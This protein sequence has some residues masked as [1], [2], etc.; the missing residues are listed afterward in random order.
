M[1]G[2]SHG[3]KSQAVEWVPTQGG[4]A[5]SIL[6]GFQGQAR[7]DK[8]HSNL[9]SSQFGLKSARGPFHPGLLY[10]LK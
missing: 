1:E 10:D 8:T 4:C 9:V 3:E 2:H 5:A 7:P 6:G